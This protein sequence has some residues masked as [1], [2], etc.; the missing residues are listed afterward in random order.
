MF[1]WNNTLTIIN[2]EKIHE[3]SIKEPLRI[4]SKEVLFYWNLLFYD[5]ILLF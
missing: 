1:F 5:V 3:Q 4:F 2:L